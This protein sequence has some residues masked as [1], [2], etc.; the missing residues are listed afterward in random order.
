MDKR[1]IL[2]LTADSG[3]GHRSA[4]NAVAAALKQRKESECE[5]SIINPIEDRRAPFFLRDS[6]ADYDRVVRKAPELYRFGYDLSDNEIPSFLIERV[7]TVS[8]YEIMRDLVRK[9][10]PDAIVVTYPL[11]QAPLAALFT[12]NQACIP[13]ISV[14]TDLV[15][16]HRIWFSPDVELCL[17]P[18]QAVHSLALEYGL[19]QD[20]IRITGIPVSPVFAQQGKDKA[21]VRQAL[22]WDPDRITFLAVGSRRVGHL[23]EMLNVINH[24]GAPIQIVVVA[25]K[26]EELYRQLKDIDWHIPAH[27]YDF[28]E[29]MPELMQA[30][31]AVICKAGGLIVTEALACGLPILLVDVIPGQEEG[32]RDYVLES[33]V[34][35]MLETPLEMLETLAHWLADGGAEMKE[36]AQ[37][38]A[39]V[40][41]PNSAVEAA[42]LIWQKAQ[43][44]THQHTRLNRTSLI[45]MLT[46][47][48]VSW[49][50]S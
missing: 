19:P 14:V 5:V 46:N 40:G 50:D 24:F 32:N 48:R 35:L 8:M 17:V 29:N 34:G 38:S 15:N 30:S 16:V 26:D 27:I 25:G 11:Y 18:T 47:H 42:D 6:A 4:A 22:G 43:Q 7:V 12:I 23:L 44:G 2:I 39:Q 49:R 31:D 10:Q 33:S 1:R 36:Y 37:N 13:M 3:F 20:K 28:V 21:A 45:E 41:R 9:S